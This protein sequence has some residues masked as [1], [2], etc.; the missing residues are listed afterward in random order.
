MPQPITIAH[1]PLPPTRNAFSLVPGEIFTTA[2]AKD[3]ASPDA[4]FYIYLA[5]PPTDAT[6]EG[7][8]AICI[9]GSKGKPLLPTEFAYIEKNIQVVVFDAILNIKT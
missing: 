1:S 9:G 4:D 3:V 8:T 6:A 7:I 2:K 5:L